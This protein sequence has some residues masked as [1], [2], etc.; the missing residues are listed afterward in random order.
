MGNDFFLKNINSIKINVLIKGIIMR[1]GII[2][3]IT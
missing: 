2:S 1:Y 3:N